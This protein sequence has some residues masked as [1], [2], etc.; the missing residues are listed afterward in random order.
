MGIRTREATQVAAIAGT[1]T[2][3]EKAHGRLILRQTR[4]RERAES[5]YEGQSRNSF[6]T[7][8]P[9][10]FPFPRPAAEKLLPFIWSVPSPAQPVA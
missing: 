6:H 1:G 3:D 5:D 7:D 8:S 4:D 10:F 2:G 9:W